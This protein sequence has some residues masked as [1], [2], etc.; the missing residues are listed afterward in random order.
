LVPIRVINSVRVL[1]SLGPGDLLTPVH[2]P[3]VTLAVSDILG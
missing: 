1:G 3:D 2:L